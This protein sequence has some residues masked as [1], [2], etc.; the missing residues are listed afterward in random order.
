MS[1]WRRKRRYEENRRFSERA[2][3]ALLAIGILR[4][5]AD[6]IQL[7]RS[8]EDIQQKLEEGRE[9]LKEMRQA[10]RAPEQ[11]D[12][13]TFALAHN[14]CDSWKIIPEDASERLAKDIETLQNAKEALVAVPGL[15][16]TEET[17][18]DIEEI[19][20]RI[21]EAEAQ[22]MRNNLVN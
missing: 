3:A 11:V 10:L 18:A 7:S 16:Q 14:L 8:D 12:D 5:S 6:G 9:L 20:G 21:S 17:L 1:V 19:A 4:N 22:Q 2:D 13:Y 15:E